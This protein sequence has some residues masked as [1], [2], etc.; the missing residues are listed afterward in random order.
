[1]KVAVTNLDIRLSIQ[2]GA[3]IVNTI[4]AQGLGLIPCCEVLEIDPMPCDCAAWI[5][6]LEHK[7]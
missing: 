7:K 5:N 1:M 4:A 3:L 2:D 6:Y